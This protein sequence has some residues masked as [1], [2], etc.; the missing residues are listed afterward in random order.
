MKWLFDEHNTMQAYVVLM[1]ALL[2]TTGLIYISITQLPALMIAGVMAYL[3]SPLV[4]IPS[5]WGRTFNCILF[6]LA[7][8]CV[9]IFLLTTLVPFIGLQALELIKEIPQI[10]TSIQSSIFELTDHFP[11]YISTEQLHQARLHLNSVLAHSS[12]SG[13]SILLNIL[14][15]I[16]SLISYLLLVP[17]LIFLFL[18]D[19]QMIIQWFQSLLPRHHVLTLNV[20]KR[21]NIQLGHYI[22]AKLLESIITTV[23]GFILYASM[24][25]KYAVLLSFGLGLSVFIPI[26]GAVLATIPVLLIAYWQWGF[27]HSFYLL[28]VLQVLLLILEGNL[29]APWLFSKT[30]HLHPAA[31]LVAILYFGGLWGFWGVFFAIPLTLIGMTLLNLWRETIHHS[32]GLV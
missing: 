4:G 29:L 31:A 13:L 16:I 15:S 28:S 8:L 24:G 25:L 27:A 20:F 12:Q 22:R 18:K 14:P 7:L 5:P 26:V 32:N 9:M 2:L 3:I 1:G 30:I 17:L 23:L 6:V 21:I 19:H 11:S 10:W